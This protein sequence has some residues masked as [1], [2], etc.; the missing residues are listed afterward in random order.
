MH[1]LV[2]KFHS[3]LADHQVRELLH[4]RV[5]SVA[6]APGLLQKYYTREASTGD[7]VGVHLFDSKDSLERYRDS[8]LSRSLPLVYQ[9]T[10]QPR[11]EVFEVLFQ[12]RSE[13][14]T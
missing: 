1:V 7:Y 14:E 4:R 9:S 8:E 11:V 2:V 13:P 12:L 6:A 3:S 10:A 5:P